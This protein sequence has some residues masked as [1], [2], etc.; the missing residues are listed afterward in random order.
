MRAAAAASTV[1]STGQ[2]IIVDLVTLSIPRRW[3]LS[4]GTLVEAPA[5]VRW[6]SHDRALRFGGNVFQG[7][8]AT[9][10]DRGKR[11]DA[12]GA[13]LSTQE[14]S[15]AGSLLVD[16]RTHPTNAV[17]VEQIEL[18][19]L[20]MLGLLDG[21]TLTVDVAVL[22]AYPQSP[23]AE[24][25]SGNVFGS[26]ST[27]EVTQGW[28]DGWTTRMSLASP[29]HMAGVSV[30]RATISP[31]C[32]WE[33]GSA[34][35][36]GATAAR[37]L[38]ET[39]ITASDAETVTLSSASMFNS[40]AWRALVPMSGRNMGVSRLIGKQG[41]STVCLL[42][43]PFPWPMAGVQGAVLSQCSLDIFGGSAASGCL[44][45][46]NLDRFGGF[47]YVPASETV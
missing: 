32:R 1:L 14:A 46:G 33:Y 29:L 24:I 40:R 11:V 18:S 10:W 9:A 13:E 12:S 35:C 4:D 43:E 16:W 37:A 42:Q 30:P 31:Y 44:V 28:R 5:V 3:Y 36:L 15:L 39:T 41:I 17:T 6:T 20:A 34:E 7:L 2:A 19:E 21:A 26:M 45:Q 25:A 27:F 22:S 23:E 38:T 8:P 47:P